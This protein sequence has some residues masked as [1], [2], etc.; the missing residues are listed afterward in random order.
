VQAPA[1][2]FPWWKLRKGA[3]AGNPPGASIQTTQ[4]FEVKTMTNLT[5][6]SP[7]DRLLHQFVAGTPRGSVNAGDALLRPRVDIHEET[8]RYVLHA[9]LPGVKKEDLNVEVEGDQLI[10]KATREQH[11]KEEGKSI[12]SERHQRIQYLRSFSLGDS[13]DPDKIEGNLATAFC[14]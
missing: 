3:A 7:A 11:A 2:P 5:H 12:H 6:W 9:D 1:S 10:L 14:D 13:V 4:P 8:D